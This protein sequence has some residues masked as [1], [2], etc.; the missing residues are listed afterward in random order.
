MPQ[1]TMKSRRTFIEYHSRV[2]TG[3]PGEHPRVV[4]G[5]SEAGMDIVDTNPTM[6]CDYSY[7][8]DDDG[9]RVTDAQGGCQPGSDWNERALGGGRSRPATS[10]VA[11]ASRSMGPRP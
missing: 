5:G 3:L 6:P 11:L 7:T 4:A 10:M 2:G 9:C 8:C 1:K